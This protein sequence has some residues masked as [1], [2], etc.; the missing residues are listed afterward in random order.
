MLR[1]L[2]V[3]NYEDKYV[4]ITGCDSGFGNILAK[5]LDGMGLHVFAG[6]FTE[7][8]AKGLKQACSSNLETIEID[9]TNETSIAKA[10]KEVQRRL[11]NDKGLWALVNNAGIAGVV[12][13]VEWLTKADF[14]QVLSINLYGVIF[15]TKA[16]LPLVRRSPGRIVN[17]A[18]VMGRFTVATAPYTVS[19]F[20]VEGFSDSLRHELYSTGVSVHIIEPGFF[21]TGIVEEDCISK[22]METRFEK[23]DP[24][25]KEYYGKEYLDTIVQ[26][27]TFL[28]TYLLSS[29]LH[30]VVDSY[31]HAVTAKY[32]KARYVVGWDANILFR[33]LWILP[34]WLSD[35]LVCSAFPTPKG[36]KKK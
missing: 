26:R 23:A 19:K 18:S 28:L 27:S 7:A 4:F 35:F 3:D 10:A 29:K 16:F 8:G 24:E 11:P 15:V 12:S 33:F 22:G 25:V 13:N 1:R 5:K 6:C 2:R 20:G 17:M 30:K 21:R 32:P 36:R 34:E 14:D 9:V 31:V